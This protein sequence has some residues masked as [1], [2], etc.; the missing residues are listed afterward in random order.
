MGP[1][2]NCTQRS[3]L[4]LT[5]HWFFKKELIS[6]T[7]LIIYLFI[8]SA[9]CKSLILLEMS[10]GC[11]ADVVYRSPRCDGQLSKLNLDRVYAV[12]VAAGGPSMRTRTK[13]VA[14]LTD[15]ECKVGRPSRPFGNR[16][17]N[18]G[19]E[20]NIRESPE[21]IRESL[22]KKN[23]RRTHGEGAR[24]VPRRNQLAHRVTTQIAYSLVK[25]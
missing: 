6:W 13:S 1:D 25:K 10:P 20:E 8:L 9:F 16:G 23:R 15:S 12:S 2:T 11:Q 3:E 19:I 17:D 24:S 21:N 7:W 22:S 18:S 14:C 4:V 5:K